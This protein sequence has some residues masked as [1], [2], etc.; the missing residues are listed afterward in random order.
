MSNRVK[1]TPLE[2]KIFVLKFREL[3]ISFAE[4]RRLYNVERTALERWAIKYDHGG[5]E[6]LEEIKQ[7]TQYSPQ[8]LINAVEDYLTGNFSML[9]IVKKYNLSGDSVLRRWLKWY[10]TPKW[11]LKLGEFMA[12]K[13]ISKDKKLELVLQYIHKIKPAKEIVE[14]ND[15]TKRQL[16]YWVE[17]YKQSGIDA[18]EDKRGSRKDESGLSKE[19]ILIRENK[20]L[21][22]ELLLIKKLKE[23]ERGVM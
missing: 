20:R 9:Q 11:N 1:F 7:P 8:T 5:L 14:E 10:N 4:F 19:E 16:R 2:K 15:I 3:N 17:K 23:L 22:A 18:L 12:R 21:K 13:K 6:A